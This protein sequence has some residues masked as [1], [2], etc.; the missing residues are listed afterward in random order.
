MDVVKKIDKIRR[1]RGWSVN[2]LASEAML[3][4]STVA[5][6][7]ASGSEPKLSTLRAICEAYN[8]SLADLFYEETDH[9][10]APKDLDLLLKYE[11]LTEKE[12]SVVN[13]LIDLLSHR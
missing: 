4:Q 7:F 6:M 12:K 11:K 2:R 3:T 10:I 5:N 1:D 9:T 13:D 8:M